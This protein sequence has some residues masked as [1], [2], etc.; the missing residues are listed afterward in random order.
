MGLLGGLMKKRATQVAS[1]AIRADKRDFMEGA[2][3]GAV[4][5]CASDGK[6]EDSEIST[7]ERVLGANDSLKAFSAE[8]PQ[9]VSKQIDLA[10]SSPRQFRLN[11]QKQCSDVSGTPEE[12]SNVMAIIL[13][14]A[15]QGG[16]DDKELVRVKEIAGWL[17]VRLSDFGI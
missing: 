14:V 5:I 17:G 12:K 4:Y 11:V 13:D 15:D 3:C 6:I 2:V 10:N 7:L 1:A 16:L 8:L 9:Y